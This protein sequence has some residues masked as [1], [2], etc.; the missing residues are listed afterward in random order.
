MNRRAI[1]HPDVL[2]KQQHGTYSPPS[3]LSKNGVVDLVYWVDSG[4]CAGVCPGHPQ[5]SIVPLIV[6]DSGPLRA[7]IASSRLCWKPGSAAKRYERADIPW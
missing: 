6:L 2:S 1:N 3:K 4:A 5:L 7:R